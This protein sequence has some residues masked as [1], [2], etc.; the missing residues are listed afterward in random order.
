MTAPF[1]AVVG[2]HLN[3]FTSGVARFN[4]LLAERMGVP[5]MG[6]FDDRLPQFARPLLSFK[7]AEL[8]AEEA[9]RLPSVLER[10]PGLRLFLH[11][12]AGLAIEEQLLRRADAVY[13]GNAAIQ[14]RLQA[15]HDDVRLAWAPGLILDTRH[16][17]PAQTSVFSF[18]MAHKIRVEMFARLRELLEASGRSYAVYIS[19]AN[20][21]TATFEDAQSVYE[22]M[23]RVFDRGLY[24]MGNLSDVAVYNQLVGTTFFAAFFDPGV[25]ANNTSVASAMEFGAVVITNLDEHSPAELVHMDNVIDINFAQ[26]LP[27]DPLVLK[28][29]SVRAM[30]TARSR[31]WDQLIEALTD[32]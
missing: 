22:D 1:D 32:A 31:G 20:H 24:F 26:D 2:H 4:Q 6:L 10:L 13:C 21:E 27:T 29:I 7:A 16:Y 11:G 5:V 23:H 19:N 14:A 12:Y 25:R 15:A 9:A 18:G 8:S 30:Q 17:T 28:R 3:P